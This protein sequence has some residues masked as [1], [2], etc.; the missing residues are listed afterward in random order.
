MPEPAGAERRRHEEKS[1][2]TKTMKYMTRTNLRLIPTAIA[3]AFAEKR[4]F[5]MQAKFR[6][7]RMLFKALIIVLL[8]TAGGIATTASADP[9]NPGDVFVSFEKQGMNFVRHYDS[10]M[11]LLQTLSTGYNSFAGGMAF[12]GNG[13]LFVTNFNAT[14]ISRFSHVDGS[15]LPAWSTGRSGHEDILFDGNCNAWVSN[16]DAGG[17]LDKFSSSG[18]YL[19]TYIPNQRTDWIDLASDQQTMFYTHE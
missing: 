18:V 6:S 8:F 11:N 12:D 14:F 16:T 13:D 19:N 3:S 5:A 9:I 7:E 15:A 4:R 1:E 17:G 2:R 10:N